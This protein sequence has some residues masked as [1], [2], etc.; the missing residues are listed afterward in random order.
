MGKKIAVNTNRKTIADIEQ[1]VNEVSGNYDKLH[2]P[3]KISFN[4]TSADLMRFKMYCIQN[5][6]NQQE[7][8]YKLFKQWIDSEELNL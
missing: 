7:Q 2:R 3:H 4:I 5:K 6:T 1:N 8:A